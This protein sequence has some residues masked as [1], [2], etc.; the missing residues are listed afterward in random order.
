MEDTVQPPRTKP[1]VVAWV[2]SLIF[3]FLEYAVRSGP[4]V[5]IPELAR[6]F[7]V[8]AVGVGAILGTYYYTYSVAGLVAGVALDRTGAKY[9]LPTG[10]AIVALGCL[11][12]A[13]PG[14]A[15]GNS[16]RLLQGAGSAFA[17]TG[18][19][20]LASRG[21]QARSLATAIGATQC[22][23][24]L[25]GAL[26]QS[27]VGPLIH[28][29]FDVRVFWVLMGL[30]N[31]ATG[32][33]LYFITPNDAQAQAAQPTAKAGLL[34]P[35]KIV[36][37]NPQSYLCGLVAGLLFAPTTI[38]A[39]NWGVAALQRDQHLSYT[40]AIWACSMVPLGWV[41]GCP[42]LGWLADRLGR[43]KPVIWL[44]AGCMV[45]LGL[46]QLYLPALMP[47]ALSLLLFGVASGA[48]MIPYS[49]I[50][51]ANPDHVKGSATGAMNFLTFGVS[52]VLGP[53][54]A[55]LYGQTLGLADPAA[56]FEKGG[57]FWIAC[58]CLALLA[59]LLL[60]ETGTAAHPPA[61]YAV[62]GDNK[63]ALV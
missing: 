1:Y 31:L 2:F 17:F 30:A 21:F 40:A 45:L 7:G 38:F 22:L 16:G 29:G 26:G 12:F 44:G 27:L 3:Y 15:A 46:Q 53:L 24:M 20:Y 36:F 6:T 41:V 61:A 63:P 25:G 51:E 52:A 48:A 43:R 5:M 4:A 49:I 37:G 10:I 13:L 33:A 57:L 56:H 23:G 55:R 34:A 19:V 42:A 14:A 50:K 58:T 32:V 54:F 59:S 9:A 8:D 47:L 35:Y 28:G 18:S 39:M 60:R 11:L 62:A